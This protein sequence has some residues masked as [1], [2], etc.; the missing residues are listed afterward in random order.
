[1]TDTLTSRSRAIPADAAPG[2]APAPRAHEIPVRLTR[3]GRVIV[4]AVLSVLLLAAFSAGRVSSRADGSRPGP[5]RATTVHAGDTLWSIA[6]RTSPGADPRAVIEGIV[7]ANHLESSMLRVGQ[8][9]VL[10]GR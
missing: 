10:P 3:R 4:V 9:L 5:V 2:G 8:R 1:M 6:R 7:A